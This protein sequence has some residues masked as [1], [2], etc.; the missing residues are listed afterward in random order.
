MKLTI[1]SIQFQ[2]DMKNIIGYSE[3]FL[4][5]TKAGKV[6]FF[7]NLGLEVKN[8]L[9]EFID[10]KDWTIARTVFTSLT[11]YGRVLISSD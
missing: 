10:S 4:D 2:K 8:I 5:G 6:L 7:R 9:E 11:L 1:N 3:G